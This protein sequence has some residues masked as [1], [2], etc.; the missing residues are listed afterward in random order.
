MKKIILSILLM[1]LMIAMT[2]CGEVAKP[3]E[4]KEEIVETNTKFGWSKLYVPEDFTYRPDL[5]GLIYSEDERKLYIKGDSEDRSTAVIIDLMQEE[6]NLYFVQYIDKLNDNITDIKY[7][8]IQEKPV[9]LFAREK[10]EGKSGDTIIYNYTYIAEYN[11]YIYKY[12]ISGPQSKE[13]ELNLLKE[14][15]VKSLRMG[16]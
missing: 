1:G 9:Q 13:E 6:T 7:R 12:T 11:S 10:Y 8:L 14:K 5:R 15:L 16:A 3:A 4:N 2:G